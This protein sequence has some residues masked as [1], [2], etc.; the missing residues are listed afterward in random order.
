MNKIIGVT[1]LQRQFRAIFDEVVERH[2]PYILTRGS[3]P[4]AV[5]IS[6]EEYIQLMQF[7]ERGIL[8]RFDRAWARLAAA[9]ASFSDEE[10][11]ADLEDHGGA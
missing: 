1:D 7:S 10:I 6:Y 8:E 5:M 2:T 3:R 4:E 11:D 9:N